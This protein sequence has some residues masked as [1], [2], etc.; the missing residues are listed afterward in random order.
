MLLTRRKLCMTR[1]LS[2]PA[3]LTIN[4]AFIEI[5]RIGEENEYTKKNYNN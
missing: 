2:E 1:T 3:Q 4:E 5:L